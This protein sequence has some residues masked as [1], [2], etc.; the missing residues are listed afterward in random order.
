MPFGITVA[1]DVVQRKLDQCFGKFYQVIVIE[2]DIMVV[3]KQHNHKDHDK[4]LQ[5]C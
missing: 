5:I 3:G 1:G 4:H 2:N